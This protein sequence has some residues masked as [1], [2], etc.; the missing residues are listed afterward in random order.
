VV[1][2]GQLSHSVTVQNR[3]LG[4]LP[5]QSEA[6]VYLQQQQI[7]QPIFNN[8]DLGGYLIYYLYP[9]VQVFTDNRPEAYGQKFFRDVYIPMQENK[10]V[11]ETQL[12]EHSFQTIIFGN[13]DI[14][15]WAQT[16]MTRI[17]D[18]PQWSLVFSDQFVSIWTFTEQEANNA[19]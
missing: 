5:A 4:L 18:D 10:K 15:P 6:I 17:A 2:S 1:F 8:Y 14:T 16:F 19:S 9:Q 12:A 3:G 13:R 7:K 11:W